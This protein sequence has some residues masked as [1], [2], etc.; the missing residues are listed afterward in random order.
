MAK[1]MGNRTVSGAP[2]LVIFTQ[3]SS[4]ATGR[5]G[6]QNRFETMADSLGAGGIKAMHESIRTQKEL[7]H[8]VC[9]DAPDMVFPSFFRLQAG[10]EDVL[11]FR[12]ELINDCVAWEKYSP[13][14]RTRSWSARAF[15]RDGSARHC[16]T[17]V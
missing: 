6:K 13:S 4:D 10:S 12:E 9:Q 15:A 16:G 1:A 5:E 11:Y 17:C 14:R 7:R 3:G 8:I 2:K